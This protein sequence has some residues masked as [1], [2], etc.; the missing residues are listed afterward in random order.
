MS[1]VNASRIKPEKPFP[2]VRVS[3]FFENHA[4]LRKVAI[5]APHAIG[6]AYVVERLTASNFMPSLSIP[7]AIALFSLGVVS[8]FAATCER[9]LHNKQIERLS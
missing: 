5:Y 8:V 1:S 9:S 2:N 6:A 7:Y 4:T 3:L